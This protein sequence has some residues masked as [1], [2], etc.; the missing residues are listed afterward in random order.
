MGWTLRTLYFF[1]QLSSEVEWQKEA[2][3]KSHDMQN[4]N[5]A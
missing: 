1:N 3:L 5:T 4:N 2:L